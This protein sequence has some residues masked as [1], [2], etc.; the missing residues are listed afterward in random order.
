MFTYGGFYR[1]HSA[2][3]EQRF[4]VR[5]AEW[6]LI[7]GT[8]SDTVSPLAPHKASGCPTAPRHRAAERT[9]G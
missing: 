3:Q 2:A 1:V 6:R 8:E 7:L 4:P 9:R 5:S